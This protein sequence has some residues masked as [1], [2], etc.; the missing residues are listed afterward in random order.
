MCTPQRRRST[1]WYDPSGSSPGTSACGGPGDLAEKV[2]RI[3]VQCPR[4]RQQFDY[5][6]PTPTTL[7][8]GDEALRLAEPRGQFLL[9]EV[10]PSPSSGQTR[11]DDLVVFRLDPQRRCL[12]HTIR[13]KGLNPNIRYWKSR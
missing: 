8:L 12:G 9:R 5:I 3:D 2:E 11:A 13:Q 10:C 6:H 7:V 1:E 4:N